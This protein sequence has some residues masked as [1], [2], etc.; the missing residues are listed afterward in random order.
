MNGSK[1]ASNNND[2]ESDPLLR[3]ETLSDCTP[4]TESNQ[5]LRQGQITPQQQQATTTSLL[6]GWKES[7]TTTT[8]TTP[9]RK[10]TQ[11]ESMMTSSQQLLQNLDGNALAFGTRMSICITFSSLFMLIGNPIN[12]NKYPQGM[13]VIITV[14]FVCWFPSLDAASVV[15]KCIQRIYGTIIGATVALLCGFASLGFWSNNKAM[16]GVFVGLCICVYTFI[17]CWAAL[18]FYVEGT[19]TKI[20]SRYNYA[21]ILCLLT[22]YICILPFYSE[23]EKR[24][25]KSLYRVLNVLIGC[26]MGAALSI[27]ILPRS[28]TQILQR[29]IE[30][31]IKLAGEASMAVLH[32]AA[33]H[34]SESA[35]IPVPLADEM[36]ESTIQDRHKRQYRIRV[37]LTS[38]HRPWRHGSGHMD[39]GPDE[40]LT[41]EENA[42]QESR[43]I[44]SQLAMLRY[45]PFQVNIPVEVMET[46]RTEVA[47]T[48]ARALRIQH[49]VVLIDGIVRNDPKHDFSEAHIKLFAIVGTLI[50]EM[51]SIPL[52]GDA[53][54]ELQKKMLEIRRCIVELAA[55]VAT[56]AHEMPN[57]GGMVGGLRSSFLTSRHDLNTML[58]E[59]IGTEEEKTKEVVTTKMEEDGYCNLVDVEEAEIDDKGGRGVPKLVH[60]SRVCALL[61]LQLVEHLALRSVRLYESWK[62]CDQLCQQTQVL[63]ST[64]H[65]PRRWAFDI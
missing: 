22:F 23:E 47:H 14:L 51:L 25:Q 45:D 4:T 13:W 29:K 54:K 60:G 53:A 35:Y 27:F 36:L 34:F 65:T 43:L 52:N 11:D 63:R 3:L 32:H 44:K 33:D 19:A 42:I 61:F 15:E 40:A 41:K 7:T 17:I 5:G 64:S 21:C 55:V 49:T 37:S 9:M 58:E 30:T 50:G 24:W 57:H 28:T 48:L 38:S 12:G 16:Q 62:S 18:Q 56:S 1:Y 2:G 8:T 6:S 10:L 46:F 59:E 39:T 20:I 31:Q 26:I